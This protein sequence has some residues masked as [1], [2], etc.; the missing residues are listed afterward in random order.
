[1]IIVVGDAAHLSVLKQHFPEQTS[2][3]FAKF[4]DLSREILRAISPEV[5]VGPLFCDGFDCFD[6]ARLLT[7]SEFTGAFRV[8]G[9]CLPRPQMVSREIKQSFPS[10]DT[11]VVSYD[12][13]VRETC[14]TQVL[15]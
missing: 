9:E 2:V 4:S 10:L 8:F 7:E 11:A 5:V 14:D 6:L 15:H 13:P 1:M 12:P 3:F